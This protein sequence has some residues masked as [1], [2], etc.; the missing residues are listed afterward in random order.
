VTHPWV[1][2]ND[3]L[4]QAGWEPSHTNEEAFVVAEPESAVATA[5]G[6]HRQEI[7]LVVAGGV[8]AGAVGGAIALIVRARRR[9]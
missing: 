7:P 3:R 6:R 4:R 9:R 1:V 5:V 2:A 8:I